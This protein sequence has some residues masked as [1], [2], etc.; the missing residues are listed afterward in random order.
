MY[1]VFSEESYIKVLEKRVRSA[2]KDVVYCN[3]LEDPVL[4]DPSKQF[5][6]VTSTYCLEEACKSH[7]DLNAAVKRM[8]GRLYT[9]IQGMAFYKL[10]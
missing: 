10:H 5:D 8:A 4:E 9:V 6:V 7:E 1:C 2:V 3:V